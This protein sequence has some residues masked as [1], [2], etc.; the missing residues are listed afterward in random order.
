MHLHRFANVGL[1]G[2]RRRRA[3]RERD[4]G[5]RVQLDGHEQRELMSVTAGASGSGN[6]TVSY[7]VAGNSG[8][9]S[10]TGTITAAGQTITV[11]QAGQT[12]SYTVSS[13]SVSSSAAGGAQSA[14]VTAAAGCSWTAVS[15]A[16]WISVTA[17]STGSGNGTVSY[18]VDANTATA[19][20]TGTIAVAGETITVTQAG[21]ACSY[22]VSPTSVSSSAAGGAQSATVTAAAGCSWTAVS[23]TAWVSVSAGSSGSGNGTVATPSMRTPRPRRAPERVT[24]AGQTVTVTQAGQSAPPPTSACPCT[25]WGASTT[26]ANIT[27]DAQAVELG[28][29]FRSDVSGVITGVRFYK[30]TTNTGTHTGLS[31]ERERHTGSR[32]RRSP[33]KPRR[34]GSR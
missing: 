28:V 11:T 31:V 12:C 24:V 7:T 19:S 29:K 30:G 25:I 26:P 33:A 17:G 8:T 22:I 4:G 14:T 21:Q 5:E 3:E 1:V 27:S 15:N 34:A 2:C 13:T 23:N 20:R 6:G 16:A 32:P 18:A 10:R 9:A